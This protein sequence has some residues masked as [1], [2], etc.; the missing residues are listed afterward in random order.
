MP[1]EYE[2]INEAQ[3]RAHLRFFL[4]FFSPQSFVKEKCGLSFS[5]RAFDL[6][7]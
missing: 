6:Q 2:I 4:P 1:S 3:Q 5:T 7:A